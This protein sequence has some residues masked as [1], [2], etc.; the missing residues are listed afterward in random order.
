[1]F[2]DPA[3]LLANTALGRLG[4]ETVVD[5]YALEVDQVYDCVEDANPLCSYV[6]YGTLCSLQPSLLGTAIYTQ[7]YGDFGSTW[8]PANCP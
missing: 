3:S 5:P 2:S 7:N 8:Q 1:L 4:V 6:S